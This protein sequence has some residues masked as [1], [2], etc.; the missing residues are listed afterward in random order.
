MTSARC[1]RYCALLKR[2]A[3]RSAACTARLIT[4]T[5]MHPMFAAATS[6]RV[7]MTFSSHMAFGTYGLSLG[8]ALL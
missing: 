7:F 1:M 6:E 5:H 3:V 8:E 4:N 2:P